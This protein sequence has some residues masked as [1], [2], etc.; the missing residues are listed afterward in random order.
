MRDVITGMRRRWYLVLVGLLITGGLAAYVYS[1]V[2]ASYSARLSL[3]LLPPLSVTGPGENPF[4]N[5]SGMEPAMDVLTRRV[6]ADVVRSPLEEQFPDSE[7]VVFPDASA[8][9]PMVVAEIAAPS[10]SSALKTLDAVNAELVSTFDSMQE[11]LGVPPLGRMTLTE[12]SVD[13]EATL[14]TK[15]RTQLVAATVAA[16]VAVTVL[17]T[18]IIDGLIMARR[19]RRADSQLASSGSERDDT[20]LL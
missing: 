8:R 2:P 9:G 6:D 12:V 18:A 20:T 11:E 7:Y 1:V 15:M 5:L 4:L 16:G 14:D 13:S 19:A 17:I 10:E 3:L